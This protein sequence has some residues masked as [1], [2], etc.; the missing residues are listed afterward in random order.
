MGFHRKERVAWRTRWRK[1]RDSRV[2]GRDLAGV[3]HRAA[4]VMKGY[5]WSI[6]IMS[7]IVSVEYKT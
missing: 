7:Y 6:K 5:S 4:G 2:T 3:T 1:V